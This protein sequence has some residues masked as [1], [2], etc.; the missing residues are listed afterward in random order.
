MKNH[1]DEMVAN[2][3]ILVVILLNPTPKFLESKVNSGHSIRAYAT[4]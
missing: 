4:Q 3:S 1:I 2:I